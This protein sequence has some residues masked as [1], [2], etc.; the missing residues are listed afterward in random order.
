MIYISI[1]HFWPSDHRGQT[2]YRRC[3]WWGVVKCLT[4]PICSRVERGRN[5]HRETPPPPA[6]NRQSPRSR[7]RITFC[8]PLYA[9][10]RAL[11]KLRSSIIDCLSAAPLHLL[12]DPLLAPNRSSPMSV[13]RSSVTPA[14]AP[15]HLPRYSLCASKSNLVNEFVDRRSPWRRGFTFRVP[16]YALQ[17][18]L[19]D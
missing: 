7:H 11:S 16:L 9:H 8:V 15:H 2:R 12:C 4:M 14:S 10:Q 5:S 13:C 18:V 1:G 6:I 19:S 3:G 17:R